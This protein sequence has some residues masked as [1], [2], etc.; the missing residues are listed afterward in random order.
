MLD[1]DAIVVD[2]CPD[3]RD[4]CNSATFSGVAGVSDAKN[5]SSDKKKIENRIRQFALKCKDHTN[6]VC[7]GVVLAGR[8]FYETTKDH[9]EYE[10]TKA[11]AKEHEK[12]WQRDQTLLNILICNV[13]PS[14]ATLLHEDYG[15][16]WKKEKAKYIAHLAG[17]GTKSG[18]DKN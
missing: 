4:I 13:F 12:E 17:P 3:M 1:A 14:N 2:N 8:Q 18:T 10:L 9:W 7:S 15:A 5:G 6:Y 11:L 16:H